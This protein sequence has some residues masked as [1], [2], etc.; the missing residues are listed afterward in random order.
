MQADFKRIVS[1]LCEEPAASAREVTEDERTALIEEGKTLAFRT[2]EQR[3]RVMAAPFNQ[4]EGVREDKLRE[5][6]GAWE[7]KAIAAGIDVERELQGFVLA[8]LRPYVPKL[9]LEI[10]GDPLWGFVPVNHNPP[11]PRPQTKRLYGA[12]TT[13]NND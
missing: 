6:F 8:N 13:G 10:P 11:A 1:V 4:E 9:E 5:L 7:Q 12:P 3:W 2:Q